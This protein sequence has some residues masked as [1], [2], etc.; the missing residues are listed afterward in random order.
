MTSSVIDFQSVAGACALNAQASR[1]LSKSDLQGLAR[2]TEVAKLH[3]DLNYAQFLQQDV[4]AL[5]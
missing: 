5:Y 3:L 4:V 2:L 1:T